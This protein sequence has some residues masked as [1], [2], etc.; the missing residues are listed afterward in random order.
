[1]NGNSSI[2]NESMLFLYAPISKKSPSTFNYGSKSF[3]LPAE[4]YV[5]IWHHYQT[6]ATKTNAWSVLCE[7]LV[8]LLFPVQEGISQTAVYRAAT[9]QGVDVSD[10]PEASGLVLQRPDDLELRI[11]QSLAGAIPVL[12]PDT[13]A[14]FCA[15]VQALTKRN[16]PVSIPDSMGAC[17]VAGYNNWDRIRAYRQEWLAADPQRT[18][19]DWPQAFRE[20]IPQKH[21]YQDRFIILSRGPYSNVAASS[22]G[23]ADDEWLSLSL[24]IRLEHECAHYF[25]KRVFGIIRQHLHDELLADYAGIVAANGRYRADWFLRFMGLEEYPHY[26]SG[27][28]LE[29]YLE[30]AWQQ[31]PVFTE[32]KQ[33]V[34]R[35]AHNLERF[36]Q[37]LPNQKRDVT[38]QTATLCGLAN[39]G[40]DK[41]AATNG[42]SL[43]AEKVTA[44]QQAILASQST[45][46]SAANN[47][48]ENMSLSIA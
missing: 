45:A 1:M 36:D 38:S 5:K 44:W 7:H 12:I 31:E 10:R 26:R 47:K 3:V 41:L 29:N 6:G 32:V 28:R 20:L 43:L 8:Q 46:V 24:Q 4:S 2:I 19:S 39:I 42:P 30:P 25:T 35:A 27:A 15:F 48:T 9:K 14:D 22:L 34:F 13:R 11:H 23:L 18:P 21:L 16:E 37:T 33:V 40:L 17:M